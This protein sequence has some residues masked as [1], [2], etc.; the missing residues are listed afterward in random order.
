[1]P[2]FRP[3]AALRYEQGCDPALVTAPPYDVIDADQRAR[4]LD[5]HPDNI[6]RVD[7]PAGE[8]GRDPYEVAPALL[9]RWQQ[10]SMLVR[11]P[12]PAFY[13][14][15]MD[16]TDDAGQA[17]RTVGVFGT[18]ALEAPG[19]GILPH[20]HTTPKARSDRL[21]MLQVC[22]ANLSAVWGLVPAEGLTDL[23]STDEPALADFV[24]ED[25]V[26]HRLWRT[27][28]A[29]RIADIAS[30][31]GNA[32]VVIA[33]GHHRFETALAY[34]QE[35]RE[36][37]GPGPW[38]A[39]LL[40]AVELS[41]AQLAVRPIHRLVSGLPAGTDVRSLLSPFFELLPWR[42]ADELDDACVA[43]LVETGTLG[44]ITPEATWRLRPRP[45]AFAGTRDL[46]TA[47]VATIAGSWADHELAYQH[48][49]ATVTRQ[50]ARREADLGLVL[51][52][53]PVAEI[54]AI[55]Q[56]GER[57]PPKTTFFHPKPRTGLVLRML[58][59]LDS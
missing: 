2:A 3:F 27:S 45:E 1:M 19:E 35:Q 36:A 53:V 34:R 13:P 5:R 39:A 59:D 47:R 58:D 49:V 41:S 30:A 16:F 10:T 46:D 31:V 32:P 18:L 12:E 57:M 48:G 24:D 15:S 54:L 7:L 55:A 44:A 6:V 20:E 26:R 8:D 38:D 52:P 56:G 17:R 43:E 29:D 33:D 23:A 40:W 25:G 51:R 42:P 21:R 9:E 14:Y 4:L 28:A 50:V 37:V 11:D 22:R